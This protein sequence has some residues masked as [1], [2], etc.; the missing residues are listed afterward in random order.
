MNSTGH[1][2]DLIAQQI[3]YV[4]SIAFSLCGNRIEAE[5]LAQDT[6]MTALEKQSDLREIAALRGW[7]RR[8]CVNL[9]YQRLRRNGLIEI[10]PSDAMDGEPADNQDTP[11]EE[12][13]IRE[14]LREIQNACFGYMAT[15]L[16]FYQRTAFALVEIFGASVDETAAILGL[17]SGACKSHLHRARR[18]LN[19]FFGQHCRHLNPDTEC[20]CS[21]EAWK[22]LLSNREATK[23]ELETALIKPDFDDPEFMRK[24]TTESL[25]KILFLFRRMP[26]AQP[27]EDWYREVIERISR[28]QR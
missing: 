25:E 14:S 11:E 19:G 5:D 21:C 7:M 12:I 1:I 13:L 24:G 26:P 3:G 23:R 22:L 4:Y 10:R 28:F 15:Q 27:D 20:R 17:S 8:I 18:N 16:S 6:L 2:N 9:L